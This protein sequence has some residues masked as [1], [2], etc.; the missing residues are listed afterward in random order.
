MGYIDVGDGSFRR[1]FQTEVSD[2]GDRFGMLVTNLI[3]WKNHQHNEKAANIMILPPT[4]QLN[5]HNKV[6]NIT[7]SPTSLSPSD[8]LIRNQY[9]IDAID[10]QNRQHLNY[11]KCCKPHFYVLYCEISFSKV[12]FK[13]SRNIDLIKSEL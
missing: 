6:T 12:Q 4:S 5:H 8:G 3:H 2:V 10:S 13:F 7:M 11:Q 9:Y 1:K